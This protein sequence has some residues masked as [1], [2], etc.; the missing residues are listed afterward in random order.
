MKLLAYILA[1][2]GLILISITL[3]YNSSPKKIASVNKH[4]KI[5]VRIL[6]NPVIHMTEAKTFT[7]LLTTTKD[8]TNNDNFI[9]KFHKLETCLQN[10]DSYC[11]EFSSDSERNYSIQILTE[12]HRIINERFENL[13][14]NPTLRDTASEL[15]A[16]EI[17]V[18]SYGPDL[19]LSALNLISLYP[20]SEENLKAIT[21]PLRVTIEDQLLERGLEILDNY[22]NISSFQMQITDLF[23]NQIRTGIS[24]ET[25]KKAAGALFRF[26]N[27]TSYA[28][29]SEVR[30]DLQKFI[31]TK[32]ASAAFRGRYLALDSALREYK[33]LS[34]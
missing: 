34:R 32:N 3:R 24:E 16:R 27:E 13:R 17:L 33:A 1:A 20:P 23:D 6:E 10:V 8:S 19:Q 11:D 29:F 15:F 5:E 9:G 18:K 7:P 30:E 21:T 26:L 22:K 2:S 31:A 25:S 28:H 12:Q 4:E 14:H